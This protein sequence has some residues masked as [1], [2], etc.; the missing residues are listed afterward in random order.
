MTNEKTLRVK[1]I[2]KLGS[3]KV[4]GKHERSSVKLA[5]VDINQ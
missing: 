4:I 5:H 2:E 1:E 3:K